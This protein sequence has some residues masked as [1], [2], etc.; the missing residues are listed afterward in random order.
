VA[1]CGG[2]GGLGA[3]TPAE[4]QNYPWCAYYMASGGGVSNCGFTSFQQ[5]LDNVRGIG[6]FCDRNTQYQPP[7]GPHPPRLQSR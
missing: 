1:I 4:A 5:C 2:L 6:G 7:A 3:A